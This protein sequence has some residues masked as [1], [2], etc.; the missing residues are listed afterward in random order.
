MQLLLPKD[1]LLS[2]TCICEAGDQGL[3]DL[4]PLPPPPL[5]GVV[6]KSACET[7]IKQAIDSDD[8]LADSLRNLAFYQRSI[9]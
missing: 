3:G 9:L 8:S 5:N 6:R 7:C 4:T 1:K 2:T